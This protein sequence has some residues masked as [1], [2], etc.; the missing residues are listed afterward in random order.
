[1]RMR[2]SAWIVL[3]A[4]AS[5]DLA[6]V[7]AN[8][9][10]YLDAFSDAH[11][12]NEKTPKLITP[13]WIGEE[14]V[15][16]AILLAIDDMSD[17]QR[18]ESYLRPILERLK[19][20][21][22]RAPVS[23][24]SNRP[25]P[26]EP[27]LQKWLKEGVT[28]ETH[29][30]NHPCPLLRQGDFEAAAREFHSCI[31]R[32]ALIPNW[33][34]VAFRMTCFD[35]INNANPRFYKEIFNKTTPQGNWVNFSSSMSMIFTEGDPEQPKGY[36]TDPD[37]R[38]RFAKYTSAGRAGQRTWINY[39]ENYP[40]P[41]IIAKLCWEI[42]SQVPDDWQGQNL[43][44]PKHPQTVEDMK[45][46]FDATV[47]KRGLFAPT[48]HPYVWI[49][50]DQMVQLL[51]HIVATQGKKAK[52]L[53]FFEIQERINKNLLAGQSLRH[54]ENAGDNGVRLIDLDADGYMDVVIG[55]EK[56]QRTRVWRPK[57]RRFD[58]TGFPLARM[59]E[60]VRFG[61]VRSGCTQQK[62]NGFASL[63]ARNEDNAGGW[64]FNGQ[65]WQREDAL[66]AGLEIEGNAILTASKG[67]DRGVRLR[68]LD[69]DG[70][71]ELIVGNPKENAVFQWLHCRDTWTRLAFSLPKGTAIVD[72]DGGDA[73]LRFVDVNGDGRDDVVFSNHERYSVSLFVDMQKGWKK[74]PASSGKRGERP[75]S[76]EVPMI[77]RKD[78]SNNGAWFNKGHM[79]VQNEDTDSMRDLIDRRAFEFLLNLEGRGKEL[80]SR[81][82]SFEGN[83]PAT[84]VQAE[85]GGDIVLPASKA[86]IFGTSLVFEQKYRNLG[87]FQSV[88][89][90]AR[91]GFE[92]QKAGVYDVEFDW[93]LHDDCAGQKFSLLIADE[94]FVDVVPTTGTWDDYRKKVF[95]RVR[96]KP[97]VQTMEI[98]GEGSIT[99]PLIDLRTVRLVPA[100]D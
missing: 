40:Y 51:D 88:D 14:G 55:N 50:N 100:K 92:V 97:G 18:Y 23:I 76:D 53:T 62:W 21:D 33:K 6:A 16:V 17:H 75:A 2:S 34:P 67:R 90:L 28:I 12:A 26:E 52:A 69:G 81:P 95:A 10:T 91:W 60:T 64:R 7:D 20:I 43:F 1:M 85:T 59:D 98:R 37:G 35:S 63:I 27:H 93:A 61:V 73:G 72:A 71:C 19:Q 49:G 45:A 38:P 68:D 9:L 48:F 32:L 65:S 31:D 42:P 77:V 30:F 86:S 57:D 80:A 8:R 66:L 78:G 82:K 25:N 4:L 84:V 15:E 56:L 36:A 99:K 58:D 11:Y 24:M 89:D 87:Y 46:G 5:S 22:G 29:T 70:S 74:I 94:K 54:P 13:Q 41:Y 79:W 39:V 44:G 47:R 83:E 96:L 3:L